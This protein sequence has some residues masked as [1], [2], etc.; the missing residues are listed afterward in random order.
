MHVH[1]LV[2]AAILAI[3]SLHLHIAIRGAQG[4]LPMRV[5]GAIGQ[6]DLLSLDAIVRSW[7]L[8]TATRSS[9]LEAVAIQ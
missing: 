8:S 9:P 4:V 7:L 2:A 6:L 5:G 1:A 3:C